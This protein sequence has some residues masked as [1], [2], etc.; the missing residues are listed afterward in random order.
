[1]RRILW[2]LLAI[3][4]AILVALALDTDDGT[5]AGLSRLDLTSLLI[6]VVLLLFVG[7]LALLF[8]RDRLSPA[9]NFYR[10]CRMT[11]L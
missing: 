4:T 2:L 11:A 10:I 1:M 7:A 8:F 5:I 3:L 9:V 6:K